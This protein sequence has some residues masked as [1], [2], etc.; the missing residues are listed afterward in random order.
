MNNCHSLLYQSKGSGIF[1][2]GELCLTHCDDWEANLRAS[3][4]VDIEKWGAEEQGVGNFS[5]QRSEGS[6]IGSGMVEHRW[7]WSN[8][9][10]H[11]TT[12]T[13][14]PYGRNDS[15]FSRNLRV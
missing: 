3:N 14:F 12:S 15:V 7:V 8:L 4:L 11:H 9:P 13:P 6:L 5:S 2:H 10:S 1:F